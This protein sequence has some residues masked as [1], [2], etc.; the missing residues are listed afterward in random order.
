VWVSNENAGTI[1]RIDPA[2]NQV[3]RTLTIGNQPLGL[4]VV[5]GSLWVGVRASNAQHRGGTLH[6]LQPAIQGGATGPWTADNVDSANGYNGWGILPLTNDGLVAFRRVG[7][8]QAATLVA[9]L[10][11]AIPAPTDGGRTYT[12]R[13]RPGVRY[14]TGATVHAV[15]IRRGIERLLRRAG[16]SSTPGSYYAGIDGARRCSPRRC[17]LSSG[18]TVDDRADTIT[19]HLGG[20]DSDFLEK[21]ALPS[22]VAVAPGVGARI[23]RP[24]PATGPYGIARMP[25]PASVI[26]VR[27]PR[28]VPIDGR[29]DGFPDRIE[30]N[31]GAP[32]SAPIRAV[33]NGR[34]DFFGGGFGLPAA[35]RAK[36]EALGT[37]YAAQLHT[38]PAWATVYAFLNTRVAPFDNLDVR[39]ALNYAVDRSAFAA[40]KG[41]PGYAT[42]T[43]QFL[44]PDFPGYRPYCPYTAGAAGLGRAWRAAD[45][46]RARRLVAHSRTR[47][48]HITVVAPR[49]FLNSETVLIARLLQ[50][51]GYRTT[52]RSL[53]ENVSLFDYVGDSR[54]RAQI[55]VLQWE[56]DYPSGSGYLQPVFS[57]AAFVPGDASQLNDSEFC[58][59]RTDRLMHRAQRL[60][61]GDPGADALWAAADRRIV[62]QAAVVPLTNPA[63]VSFVSRRVGDYQYSPQWGV[64]Y[65]Q[66]WVR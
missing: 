7:G 20:P 8:R 46:A 31:T 37:R 54:H 29:P 12:F 5:D 24:L 52:T 17:D 59:R 22:A 42:P 66:L 38:T 35:V 30:I 50:R 63:A 16:V 45:L 6:V 4:T 19:F 39:R 15:D 44:P 57:C 26:L 21:L 55:G 58:D 47:G 43:C 3:V 36:L 61:F 14:S 23:S 51:L 56:A 49:I 28:F 18:V 53:P 40:L 13:L 64:L 1:V 33:E 25:P 60:P 65:D 11:L 27:N 2:R 34:A 48:M 9:D 41:G 62:D 32:G 10:A